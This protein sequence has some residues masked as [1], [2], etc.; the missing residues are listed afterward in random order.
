M[1]EP[2]IKVLNRKR[3]T[4]KDLCLSGLIK[5]GDEPLVIEYNCR[6][7]DPKRKW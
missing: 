4:I 7:G 5:V 6:M 1:V 3:S 2:T